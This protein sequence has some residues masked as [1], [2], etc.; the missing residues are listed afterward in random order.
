MKCLL[1]YQWLKL[2]RNA[3]P[4]GKG[5]MRFWARLASR[6][7]FR[8]GKSQ[9]C[10]HTNHVTAGS[11]AG[12][13]V[14]LKSILGV[15]SREKAATV[16]DELSQF[17]YLSYHLDAKTKKLSYSILD[18]V[19][20]CSGDAC[21]AGTV[22]A[23]EGYGFL[24]IP[25]SLTDRLAAQHHVFDEADAWL[26]LWCHTVWHDTRNPLSFAA[27]A[28]QYGRKG[29]ALTLDTLGNR[30]KWE[31]TKVWRFFRKHEDAFALHKLPGSFGCLI[32]N[33]QY[34]GFQCDY[35]EIGARIM[36][37]L[38]EIRI[39]GRNTH[40]EGADNHRINQ[41]MLLYSQYHPEHESL[42]AAFFIAGNRVAQ[43][44]L[45]KRAYF[46][47]C[48]NCINSVQCI[49]TGEIDKLLNTQIR[50]PCTSYGPRFS[51]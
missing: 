22:Y 20:E 1:R 48:W 15:K 3:L 2:P 31:K 34:P 17:G 33:K 51:P 6:A 25:R 38:N 27:P 42:P 14:G 37:I 9:Y 43:S 16:L 23:T 24:C 21:A 41:L 29:I 50:G 30:W 28:V 46:S 35:G 11:W 13:M 47:D 5:V 39:W 40:F 8:A 32:V 26:D 18:W 45:Y 19:A 4:Q 10:G 49:Q 12:G 44:P 36:R 7:A